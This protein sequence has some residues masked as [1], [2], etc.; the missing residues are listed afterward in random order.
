MTRLARFR[1]GI[2]TLAAPELKVPRYTITSGSAT[3]LLAFSASLPASQAP[4]AG[5]ASS[6]SS[7]VIVKS[8]ALLPA[9][10]SAILNELT[11]VSVWPLLLPV[12]GRDETILIV[13]DCA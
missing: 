7:Y 5:V 6:I 10:S 4:R 3:A 11:I 12:R 2:D 1:I 8:P 13:D 9:S